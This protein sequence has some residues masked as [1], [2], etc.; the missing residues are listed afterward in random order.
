MP[1]LIGNLPQLRNVP[2]QFLPELITPILQPMDLGIM[3]AWKKLYQRKVVIR[4][5]D[6]A[7]EGILD[8]LYKV[9]LK[10]AITWVYD[11]WANMSGS[12]IHNCFTK[13]G[14]F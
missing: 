14:L 9:D 12:T 2:I 8:N 4:A 1:W 6:L 11:I 10:T 3:A 7:D 5:V 13:S